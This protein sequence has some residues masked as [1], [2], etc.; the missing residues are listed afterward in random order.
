MTDV[1]ERRNEIIMALRKARLEQL[2]NGHEWDIS[3]VMEVLDN[4]INWSR[5]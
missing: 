3:D 5:V 2:L 4:E 1:T